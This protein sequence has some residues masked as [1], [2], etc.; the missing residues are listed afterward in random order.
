VI[1][2][3]EAPL[4]PSARIGRRILPTSVLEMTPGQL[5]QLIARAWGYPGPALCLVGGDPEPLLAA[6]RATHDRV[7]RVAIRGMD[8]RDVEWDA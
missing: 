2:T 6:C 3:L 1:V 7:Y 4:P 5:P 8:D